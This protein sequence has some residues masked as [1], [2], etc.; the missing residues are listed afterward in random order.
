MKQLSLLDSLFHN[1]KWTFL[2]LFLFL[3]KHSSYKLQL[4]AKQSKQVV[5][6]TTLV[7]KP[8][9]NIH[10]ILQLLV[11]LTPQNQ[12]LRQIQQKTATTTMR[13][14]TQTLDHNSPHSNCIPF[15]Y[16]YFLSHF[17][18][19]AKKKQPLRTAHF[20]SGDRKRLIEFM[21]PN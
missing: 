6:Q 18:L 17:C 16:F 2:L 19:S 3:F 15:T 1:Q 20:S 13:T 9:S 8:H 12:Y 4:V 11:S 21:I 5:R 14:T 7:M 10:P